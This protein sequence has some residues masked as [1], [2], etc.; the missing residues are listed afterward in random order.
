[1][2]SS[3]FAVQRALVLLSSFVASC[4]CGEEPLIHVPNANCLVDSTGGFC[5][6]GHCTLVV[7]PGAV[8]RDTEFILGDE[9][10]PLGLR[11][12]V[13]GD[14]VCTVGPANIGLSFLLPAQLRIRY[15]EAEVPADFRESELLAFV[16]QG[17]R[18]DLQLEGLH[19]LEAD[20]LE[21]PVFAA[22]SAG[23]TAVPERPR[24]TREIGR[25]LFPIDDPASYFRNISR[26]PILAAYF[27]GK[28]L[29][30][31]NGPRVLIWNDGVPRDPA[32]PPDV[33]LGRPDLLSDSEEATGANLTGFVLGIWSDGARLVVSS[34]NRA[35]IW[36]RIPTE[37]YAAAD[38]V[39]G[40][41]DFRSNDANR[42]GSPGPN[43]LQAPDDIA[44]DGRR[45]LIADSLNNRV[46]VWNTFPVLN[47]QPADLVLGQGTFE[48]NGVRTGAI[49][50]Q[51]TRS[52]Y[53]DAERVLVGSSFGGA[54]LF[55]LTGFPTQSNPSFD[56]LVGPNSLT[57]RVDG[58]YYSPGG[59]SR[60]GPEG[61]ALRDLGG[62]R[63][64]V[65]R[66]FPA[67]ATAAPDLVLGKPDGALGG[68]ELG[69]VSAS[70]LVG[71]NG[72]LG[73]YGDEERLLVPDGSRLLIWSHLPQ[74]NYAPA[75]LVIG[76]PT[77][78]TA[79]LGV[80]YRGISA[81]T[82]AHPSGVFAQGGRLFIAD[83]SNNRVLIG[84]PGTT[85]LVLGQ[86]DPQSFRPNLDYHQP[87]AS[88][89][90]GPS[91]VYFDGTR[92]WVADT[93]NH[94]VL[95]WNALPTQAGAP[96]DLVLGQASFS[97][98]SPNRGRGQ[99]AADGLFYPSAV[100]VQGDRLYVADTFNH[101]VLI[102]QPLPTTSGAA[103]AIAVGQADLS[104][105]LP[106]H[107]SGWSQRSGEGLALPLG[108]FVED[109][110]R[111]WVADQ[112]N[113]RVLAFDPPLRAGAQ[114]AVVLGQANM[115]SNSSPN[116]LGGA[117]AGFPQSESTFL[118]EATTLRRPTDVTVARG[119]VLVTDG[120]NH[121][122]LGYSRTASRA[123]IAAELVLGQRGYRAR[124]PNAGGIS[125]RS[126]SAPGALAADGDQ[127]WVADT[128]N[129]RVLSFD[130]LSLTSSSAATAV[131][132]QVDFLGDRINGSAP[133]FDVLD[134]PSGVALDPSGQLWIAD[135]EHH[136][137]LSYADGSFRLALGQ[138]NR[139]RGLRNAGGAPT[140]R[141]LSAPTDVWTDGQ[142][143]VV[144]DRDNH[145]VLLWRSLPSSTY[146]PADVVIGQASKTSGGPNGGQ[147]V[148][149][150]GRATLL[151]PEG[152]DSDGRVL[153]ISD[154]GNNRVLVFDRFPDQ[155]GAEA[156]RVL[157][158]AD[159]EHNLANRGSPEPGDDRC[160]GPTDTL[161]V[162][163]RLYVADAQNHRVLGFTSTEVTASMVLGQRDFRSRLTV[164][165]DGGIDLSTLQNPTSFAYDGVNLFVT[166]PGNNRILVFD[167]L[168]T[169]I[170]A[171]A[172]R[173]LG[174][175]T[176]TLGIATVDRASLRSPTRLVVET[177][178]F[179]RSRVTVADSG[180][181]RVV[182][183][184]GLARL[185]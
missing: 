29:Y 158:Q 95:V 122:V 137:V 79:E 7:K 82:L 90:S 128:S 116:H 87:S 154:T 69:G 32:Q 141:S 61:L 44:S 156:S 65:W 146:A 109:T 78:T 3:W 102:Y 22:L 91:D 135:R 139:E 59:I 167:A 125:E 144:A 80:D 47:N 113:N 105:G 176:P 112:E 132:G 180:K 55:G 174:Q 25:D 150:P 54:C 100:A 53:L 162:G 170:G 2:K 45:L 19:D 153:Y 71:T 181:D 178:S 171:A 169:Q 165:A 111:L 35:L 1:M 143:L 70:S 16:V 98:V 118:T 31:G 157:C 107:G 17:D 131:V 4:S 147:G 21:V 63:V 136:R 168:P 151:A 62:N 88:T 120:F 121:R 99:T 23:L 76:Q 66:R 72:S 52:V 93:G 85:P 56:F 94:R 34:G 50:M 133:A 148:L 15:A 161:L 145:R 173:V 26:L 175:P 36:N 84:R 46:L 184:D 13:L 68:P 185:E 149:Q 74:H 57:K 10:K 119:R 20:E 103:A 27:D 101:R 12:D 110:G 140:A 67:T 160:A 138:V 123:P 18:Q 182:V 166:D 5:V 97:E 49:P 114:A 33:V 73:V 28:R 163:D 11:G 126:L 92:L 134:R 129:H 42:G 117:N 106:N 43:T 8:S 81:A 37:S 86:P 9:P 41:D 124:A 40:Q 30:V 75:D 83:K 155:D 130:L 51:Q 58:S 89:L 60:F 172:D 142:R 24:I 108:V 164:G 127:L 115:S 64:S 39:L 38:V 177:R 48:E 179:H 14:R 159:F 6:A 152:V 96:A 104:S 77:F 183:F